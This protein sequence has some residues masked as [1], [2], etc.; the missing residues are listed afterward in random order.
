MKGYEKHLTLIVND[1]EIGSIIFDKVEVTQHTKQ[2][3]FR[4]DGCMLCKFNNKVVKHNLRYNFT[5]DD[6]ECV[7]YTL[8]LTN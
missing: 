6:V 7:Y 4:Y 1:S 2:Y 8:N 3:T 5:A